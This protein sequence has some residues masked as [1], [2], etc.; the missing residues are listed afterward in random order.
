MKYRNLVDTVLIIIA[1]IVI[2]CYQFQLNKVNT[3]LEV[4]KR[5][6]E[7]IEYKNECLKDS[8]HQERM[9]NLDKILTIMNND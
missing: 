7:V 4:W 8:L 9:A 5:S 3:Q 1:A 6:H 2:G